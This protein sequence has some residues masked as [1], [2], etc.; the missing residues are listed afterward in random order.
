MGCRSGCLVSSA[1]VQAL[2]CGSCSAF[3]WSFD[4]SVGE[5]VVSLSYSSAILGPAPQKR[6]SGLGL[7]G[8]S[9]KNGFKVF[10]RLPRS[11][12]IKM[13]PESEHLSPYPVTTLFQSLFV[14]NWILNL[15]TTDLAPKS[16]PCFSLITLH[17]IIHEVARVVLFKYAGSF[18]TSAQNLPHCPECERLY[19]I[20]TSCPSP[21]SSL[22]Y[23]SSVDSHPATWPPVVPQICQVPSYHESLHC[24]PL[25]PECSSLDGCMAYYLTSGFT[26][27]PS[28]WGLLWPY[29]VYLHHCECL[30]AQSLQFCP[31][32]CDPWTI[33]LQAPLSMGFPRQEYCSGLPLPS[34]G[35]L[36]D[37]GIK[38]TSPMSLALAGRFFTTSATWEVHL[39]P[40][41]PRSLIL[42]IHSLFFDLLHETYPCLTL[43]YISLINWNFSSMRIG[44]F[45]SFSQ[46][47]TAW[48][49]IDSQ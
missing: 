3:K 37:P 26:W 17:F 21:A 15:A 42:Q 32:L 25:H 10:W 22:T 18:G 39:H 40:P 2:F 45:A 7:S 9:L 6:F 28:D 23:L 29:S 34:P 30:H 47:E 16:P 12:Y 8:R 31:T 19:I 20:C 36:P 35:H 14:W 33:A 44:N 41:H 24:F 38:L 4:G 5:N 48:H 11:H 43:L 49:K 27:M 46:S 1:S 13:Y